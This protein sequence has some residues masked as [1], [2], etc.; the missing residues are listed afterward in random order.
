MIEQVC[1]AN[2]DEGP[3]GL[4]SRNGPHEAVTDANGQP[5]VPFSPSIT[6]IDGVGHNVYV[7]KNCGCLY[8]TVML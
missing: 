6:F 8:A 1:P 4:V 7:C 5:F 2:K 3:M